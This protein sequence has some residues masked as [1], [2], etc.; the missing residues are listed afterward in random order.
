MRVHASW[1]MVVCSVA[2][3]AHLG[4][5]RR[6]SGAESVACRASSPGSRCRLGADVSHACVYFNKHLCAKNK[7][8]TFCG[9]S[10]D[11]KGPN[12]GE[13]GLFENLSP[14]WHVLTFFLAVALEVCFAFAALSYA[15]FPHDLLEF[16]L[17]DKL[18]F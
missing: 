10:F 16:G 11:E 8:I 9:T 15:V 6:T 13:S 1:S 4:V 3:C 2:L 17:Q 14:N 7:M 5:Y 12:F 18:E